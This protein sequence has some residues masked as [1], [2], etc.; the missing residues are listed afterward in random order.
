[1]KQ[2][3]QSLM[4]TFYILRHAHKEIGDYY[5]PELRHQ[6]EPIN[7]QGREA[8]QRL[9]SFFAD[10]QIS[11]IFISCYLRTAQT[12]E[13]VADRLNIT[14]VVDGRLNELDNGVFEKMSAQEIQQSY[15]DIWQAYR[16]RNRDFRFPGGETGEEA[17]RRIAAFLAEKQTQHNG[18]NIIVVCHEG[19]V[20]V[21]ACHILG[22]PV[23]DR[24]KFRVDP[25]G[26]MEIQYQPEYQK[27]QIVRFNHQI[28]P[29][30]S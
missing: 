21:T 25:C 19:L 26:I 7:A 3:M 9:W 14:P 23:Y 4:T 6:D 30:A 8:A 22:L 13:H 15:P 5:S 27:W 28:W 24:W 12:I 2:E 16:E 1:M 17:R 11:A 18:Q 29:V 20:R 10:K